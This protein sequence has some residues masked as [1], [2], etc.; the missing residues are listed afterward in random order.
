[1]I[2]LRHAHYKLTP[3][4]GKFPAFSRLWTA[5][6]RCKKS[7]RM[8]RSDFAG[9][10]DAGKNGFHVCRQLKAEATTKR[11]KIILITS[12]NQQSDRVW[13]LKQGADAYL[14]KAI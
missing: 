11:I 7:Y 10:G 4:Q 9:C 1:M 6:R 8:S 13:G 12:K 14:A 3:S 2:V 5:R